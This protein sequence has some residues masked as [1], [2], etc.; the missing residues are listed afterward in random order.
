[1]TEPGACEKPY[2]CQEFCLAITEVEVIQDVVEAVKCLKCMQS[3]QKSS[4]KQAERV[5]IPKLLSEFL[6]DL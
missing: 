4:Y 2:R 6:R 1:M 3:E 5:T